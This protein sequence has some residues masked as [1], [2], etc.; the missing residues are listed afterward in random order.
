M[1]IKKLLA[2]ATLFSGLVASGMA[3]AT[4]YG[5]E[6][7]TN[8]G[9]SDLSGQLGLNVTQFGEQ[10]L[11]TIS[12]AL[13]G[14]SSSISGVYFDFG[15]TNFFSPPSTS[16]VTTTTFTTTVDTY[17]WQCVQKCNQAPNKHVFGWAKTGSS[18]STSN[19]GTIGSS[20]T[21]TN[22]SKTVTT[23]TS[24]TS[25]TTVQNNGGI[26]WSYA[27]SSQSG[28]GYTD[29][30]NPGVLP[31][32]NTVGF[33]ADDWGTATSPNVPRNGVNPGEFVGFLGTFSNG[34]NFA[35]LISA[36]NQGDFR[37]GL[38]VISIQ[39]QGGSDSY[40]NNVVPI[41]AAGWLFGSALL[42]LMGW[43]NRRKVYS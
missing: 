30:G 26:A 36:L 16:Q 4:S 29:G 21:Q 24:K 6:N 31:G 12:N 38:H 5:F 8:N 14:I 42:G 33:S 1:S 17:A 32:G 18:S 23:T 11:F 3:G 28:V 34:G 10:A 37:V 25:T 43:S 39:P 41:P 9:N 40:V 20:T 13:G 2:A 22:T 19:T 27:N 7:I 35:A 15:S